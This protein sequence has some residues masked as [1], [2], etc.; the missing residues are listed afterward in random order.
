M[1]DYIAKP[2][3]VGKMFATLARWIKPGLDRSDGQG[4][5][6]SGAEARNRLPVR[7]WAMSRAKSRVS[8]DIK[9]RGSRGTSVKA[10]ARGRI[11]MLEMKREWG[12]EASPEDDLPDLPGIEKRQGLAICLGN[13][14]L[15][16]RF[17]RGFATASGTSSNIFYRRVRAPTGPPRP[18]PPTPRE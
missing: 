7:I 11:R 18:A 16:T 9:G 15:Y 17:W 3:D 8:A 13:G 6:R 2:L 10:K 14:Q 12:S 5:G 1:C 4:P